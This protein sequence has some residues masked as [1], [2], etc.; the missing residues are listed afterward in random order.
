MPCLAPTLPPHK[1][2]ISKSSVSVIAVTTVDVDAIQG[3]S[4]AMPCDIEPVDRDDRV[5]MVLWFREKGGKPLYR[6][7]YLIY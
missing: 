5:H 4:V 7:E 2:N 1:D 3:R 6:Y